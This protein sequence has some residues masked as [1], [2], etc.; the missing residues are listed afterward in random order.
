SPAN[1]CIR[2]FL[3]R[4]Q[5]HRRPPN[6]TSTR[7]GYWAEI[8]R[9][10]RLA[11]TNFQRDHERKGRVTANRDCTTQAQ[12]V[13]TSGDGPAYVNFTPAPKRECR[14]HLI[15]ESGLSGIPTILVSFPSG[16]RLSR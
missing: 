1:A 12:F 2:T 16:R 7:G 13:V 15:V 3:M 11:F 10:S 14:P 5:S 8:G 6:I 9:I 4:Q